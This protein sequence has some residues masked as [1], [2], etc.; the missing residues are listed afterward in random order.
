M[1]LEK[2]AL[3]AVA[4]ITVAVVL[5]F[6][7]WY[8]GHAQYQKGV[9]NTT[10]KFNKTL[11]ESGKAERSREQNL[12]AKVDKLEKDAVN[13]REKTKHVIADM[14]SN[15]DRLQQ[16]AE[17]FAKRLRANA[18]TTSAPDD[19]LAAGWS[20]FGQC[21]K[22]YAEMGAFAD[23]QRDDLAEWQK[24]NLILK[25]NDNFKTVNN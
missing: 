6:S 20:L 5:I 10:V 17:S 12:Q 2:M 23:R 21:T 18:S 15:A 14:Q 22:R 11:E 13:E 1:K 3:K 9:A 25:E 7:I 4:F 24:Y 19:T 8:Y 16:R